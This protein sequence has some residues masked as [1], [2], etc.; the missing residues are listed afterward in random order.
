MLQGLV[1]SMTKEGPSDGTDPK[2]YTSPSVLSD[3]NTVLAEPLS[4]RLSPPSATPLQD[5]AVPDDSLADDSA[6]FQGKSSMTAQAAFASDFLEHAVTGTPLMD[7]A[8]Q[9]DMHD[10][11]AALRAMAQQ[12]QQPG[13]GRGRGLSA[14]ARRSLPQKR[15]LSQHFARRKPLPR[16]GIAQLPLPPTDVVLLMLR[17]IR[18]M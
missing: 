10:A 6:S 12:Q 8:A 7:R 16:G 13:R 3:T 9:P 11:L 2:T 5:A 14:D 18:G 4:T 17:E 15:R 1:T